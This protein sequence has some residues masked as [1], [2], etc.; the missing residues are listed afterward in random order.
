MLHFQVK[1]VICDQGPTNV[2]AMK[3]L[4]ATLMLQ[5]DGSPKNLLHLGN[6]KIP[7]LFDVP[8]LFKSV[9]NNLKKHPIHVI[10]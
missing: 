7:L 9:R 4:G 5:E 1:C 8:H 6:S 3:D 2:R 10:Q